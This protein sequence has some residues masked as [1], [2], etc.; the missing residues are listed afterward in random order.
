MVNAAGPIV[1]VS[2]DDKLYG[3]DF[4]QLH[5]FGPGVMAGY[6]G[7]AVRKPLDAARIVD[8]FAG[9]VVVRHPPDFLADVVEFDDEI[10]QSATDERVAVIEADS[11]ERHV[12]CLH[13]PHDFTG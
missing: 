10:A 6:H 11:G 8:R 13:F 5:L 1:R 12:R 3:R 2:P 9:K 7:V 4:G